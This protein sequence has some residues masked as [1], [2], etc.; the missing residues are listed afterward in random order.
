MKLDFKEHE[1]HKVMKVE[2]EKQWRD[3]LLTSSESGTLV[4]LDMYALWCPPCASACPVFGKMSTE[5]EDVSFMKADI[6]AVPAIKTL[7]AVRAMPT[8]ILFRGGLE[9]DRCVGF[10]ENAIRAMLQRHRQ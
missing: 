10:S 4:V 3:A 7:N 2:S 5:Y 1:G 8:F 9:V 6:D